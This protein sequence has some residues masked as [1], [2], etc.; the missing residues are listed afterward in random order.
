LCETTTKNFK[1]SPTE[2]DD[3]EMT[4]DGTDSGQPSRDKDLKDDFEKQWCLVDESDKTVVRVSPSQAQVDP[5]EG[6]LLEKPIP[7]ISNDKFSQEDI[8]DYWNDHLSG[9]VHVK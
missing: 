6:W 9:H 4:G 5:L 7:Y 2:E 8:F 1:S 3:V